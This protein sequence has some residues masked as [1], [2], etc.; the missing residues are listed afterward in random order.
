M[1]VIEILYNELG[2]ETEINFLSQN[3]VKSFYEEVMR[4]LF[5]PSDSYYI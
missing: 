1:H 3:W 4:T 5:D 2:Y